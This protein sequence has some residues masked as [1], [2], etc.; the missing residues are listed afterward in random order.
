MAKAAV[1]GNGYALKNPA[2]VA[3]VIKLQN[4]R[5]GKFAF[6]QS[7][8]RGELGRCWLLLIVRCNRAKP[9]Q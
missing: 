7:L 6:A 9:P 1:P 4:Y 3:G 8:R 5:H 2:H